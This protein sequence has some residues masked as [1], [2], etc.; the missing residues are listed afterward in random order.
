[1]KNRNKS[2]FPVPSCLCDSTDDVLDDPGCEATIKLSSSIIF[3]TQD[4]V[5]KGEQKSLCLQ[6]GQLWAATSKLHPDLDATWCING[7]IEGA[8]HLNN[9]YNI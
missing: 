6:K 2:N 4:Q 1:M 8:K 5:Q 3:C 9:L 7:K